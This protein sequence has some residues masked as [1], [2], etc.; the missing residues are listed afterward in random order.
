MLD[1]GG[2]C[3]ALCK[4]IKSK[5]WTPWTYTM[6]YAQLYLGNKCHGFSSSSS[7]FAASFGTMVLI[8]GATVSNSA[9]NL[10]FPKL[11]LF[12][13][14]F[15]NQVIPQ[16]TI[17]Q[18]CFLYPLDSKWAGGIGQNQIKSLSLPSIKS[19]KDGGIEQT[20]PI[21]ERKLTLWEN[22]IW[23]LE[24]VKSHILC[25]LTMFNIRYQFHKHGVPPNANL[26]MLGT[27][28]WIRQVRVLKDVSSLHEQSVVEAGLAIYLQG[29]ARFGR[30]RSHLWPGRT[31]VGIGRQA[32]PWCSSCLTVCLQKVLP[33]YSTTPV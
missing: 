33:G 4:C 12:W 8:P 28:R 14:L 10:P 7:L 1:Y 26:G 16:D 19:G 32:W 29:T 24:N 31:G 25:L 6:L 5:G 20:K 22:I 18:H 11:F 23:M 21:L 3:I 17:N 9:F 27:Q 30:G 15:Y 2:N 13:L